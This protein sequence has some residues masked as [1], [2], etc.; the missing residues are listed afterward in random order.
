MIFT[1][2]NLLFLIFWIVTFIYSIKET[3]LLKQKLE[4]HKK[5]AEERYKLLNQGKFQ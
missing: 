3:R 5:E 2:I 1:I 4:Q